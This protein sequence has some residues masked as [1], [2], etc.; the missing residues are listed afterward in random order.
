MEQINNWFYNVLKYLNKLKFILPTYKIKNNYDRRL[1]L[2]VV[3]NLR[4]IILLLT[5]SELMILSDNGKDFIYHD[6]C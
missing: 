2:G 5:N 6:S 3:D 1:L 4:N